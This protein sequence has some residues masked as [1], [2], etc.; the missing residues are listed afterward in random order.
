MNAVPPVRRIR[1]AV[2][3]PHVVNRRSRLEDLVRTDLLDVLR[4]FDVE[5]V[6]SSSGAECV[7]VVVIDEHVVNTACEF[8]VEVGDLP[9]VLRI[10]NIKQ[11]DA[12][13]AVRRAFATNHTDLAVL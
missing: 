10:F 4:I 6:V 1:D 5:D 2:L 12:V 11:H 8:L 3:N 13:L 9:G 7:D